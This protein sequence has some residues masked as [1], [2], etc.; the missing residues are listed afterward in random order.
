MERGKAGRASVAGATDPLRGPSMAGATDPLRGPSAGLL[1]TGE[2]ARRSNSTLRTVRFYEEA[3]ILHPVRRSDSGHRLFEESELDRLQL[4]SD[5]RSSGLSL[6]EIR[7]LLDLK[8]HGASG[9]AAA[10]IAATALTA[11]IEEL[12]RKLDVLG[13]LRDD[14]VKSS[15]AI[16]NC[17]GCTDP[18]FPHHCGGCSVMTDPPDLPRGARVLWCGPNPPQDEPASMA[19]SKGPASPKDER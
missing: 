13:R 5:L 16:A 14:L 4:V 18:K 2:M 11:R 12:E 8:R 6:E 10:A 19:G 3:G 15:R 1:T 7:E 17:L 9:G